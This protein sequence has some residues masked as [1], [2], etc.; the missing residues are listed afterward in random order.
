MSSPSANRVSPVAVMVLAAAALGIGLFLGSGPPRCGGEPMSPGD[1]CYSYGHGTSSYDDEVAKN[2]AAPVWGAGIAALLAGWAIAIWIKESQPGGPPAASPDLLA[3]APAAATSGLGVTAPGATTPPLARTPEEARMFMRLNPCVC[4]TA[5]VP[6]NDESYHVD[7]QLLQR[8]HGPCA[9]CGRA[10]EFRFRLPAEPP[11]ESRFGD[12]T[13][14]ELID[15]GVWFSVAAHCARA[16]PTPLD[17]KGLDD[18]ARDAARRNGARVLAAIDEV[19]AFLP[20]G[21]SKVPE[22][23]FFSPQGL[24]FRSQYPGQFRRARLEALREAYRKFVA[25]ATDTPKA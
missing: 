2:R 10:R 21:A 13:P 17:T 4:G 11:G 25:E 9:S 14:S 15:P 19:M 18:A 12:G 22:S 8:Y 24:R 20:A 23:A 16:L 3:A 1:S 6:G 5:G 7:G